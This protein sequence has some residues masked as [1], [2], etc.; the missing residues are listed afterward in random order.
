MNSKCALHYKFNL[1]FSIPTF[2]FPSLLGEIE[3]LDCCCGKL[4]PN[5]YDALLLLVFAEI[6]LHYFRRT[7]LGINSTRTRVGA[8][9]F[10]FFDIS[11]NDLHIK[12]PGSW[13]LSFADMPV[14]STSGSAN[15]FWG[16]RNYIFFLGFKLFERTFFFFILKVKHAV[17]D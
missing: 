13:F 12:R 3:A 16:L 9:H 2:P 10:P 4:D 7:H 14:I 5:K 15:H 11:V 8:L 1:N 6:Q 17:T